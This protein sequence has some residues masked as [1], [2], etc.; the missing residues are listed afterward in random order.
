MKKGVF[1]M[2]LS[3]LC[4]GVGA[5]TKDIISDTT[6]SVITFGKDLMKGLNDGVDEGRK[7]AEGADGAV[8]VTNVDE[9]EQFISVEVL[10]VESTDDELATLVTVGFKNNEGKPVRIANMD[11]K[12][13]VL[14]IDHDGYS[15]GLSADNRYAA[16]FTVPPNTGTKHVFKFDITMD[17]ASKIRLWSKEYELAGHHKKK[18]PDDSVEI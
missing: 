2:A 14:L 6:K 15:Q 7:G 17:K 11:D 18:L 10:G 4:A 1:V 3:L 16:E 8:T 13:I 9:M 12:G 5:D